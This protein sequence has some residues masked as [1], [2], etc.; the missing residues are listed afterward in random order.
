MMAMLGAGPS[1]AG[2]TLL[3]PRPWADLAIVWMRSTNGDV[4][5]WPLCIG[6]P[7][8]RCRRR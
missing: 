3:P 1:S 2:A 6:R 4:M 8:P 5:I 7:V